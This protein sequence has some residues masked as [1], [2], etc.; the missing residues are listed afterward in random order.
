MRPW[1]GIF[2]GR[3]Q[4]G[5]ASGM[6]LSAPSA[7]FHCVLMD[8][9]WEAALLKMRAVVLLCPWVPWE[10]EGLWQRQGLPVARRGELQENRNSKG[11]WA[12]SRNWDWSSLYSDCGVHLMLLCPRQDEHSLPPR[13]CP[14]LCQVSAEAGLRA[15]GGFCS[16]REQGQ[17]W[18]WICCWPG[19][20]GNMGTGPCWL[21]WLWATTVG[22]ALTCCGIPPSC[23]RISSGPAV[24][25]P[26][27]AACCPQDVVG[28]FPPSLLLD[29]CLPPGC[30]QPA[31]G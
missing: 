2:A 30:P 5:T 15:T 23:R 25:C 8:L 16:Q 11:F 14:Q 20:R 9:W 12:S 21:R 24:S 13:P 3:S 7:S 27:L 4:W 10:P 6:G 29:D 31:L 1:S 28:C 17:H 26:R 19:S 18:V 22:C